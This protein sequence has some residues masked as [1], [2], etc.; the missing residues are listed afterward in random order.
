MTP[1]H[2]S[3]SPDLSYAFASFNRRIQT[4]SRNDPNFT[5]DL[6]RLLNSGDP[7]YTIHGALSFQDVLHYRL[8]P[9]PSLRRLLKEA[10]AA[11]RE[12]QV[13]A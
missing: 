6:L 9:S 5:G 1:I 2:V 12:F 8:D 4:A 11:G 10:E 7:L 13:S 3:T